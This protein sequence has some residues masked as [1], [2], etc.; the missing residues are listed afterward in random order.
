[1]DTLEYLHPA[2]ACGWTGGPPTSR[3]G[4]VG[5]VDG[6]QL[7]VI[8]VVDGLRVSSEQRPRHDHAHEGFGHV[9]RC[10]R[11]LPGSCCATQDACRTA[12]GSGN[13]ILCIH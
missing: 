3:D 1:M 9:V 8:V 13:Q 10:P 11:E 4:P 12:K 7:P 5:L 2:L 6:V